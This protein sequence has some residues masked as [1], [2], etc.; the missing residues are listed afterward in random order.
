MALFT[1]TFH[2]II[3]FWVTNR[4]SK[5]H[6]IITIYDICGILSGVQ[7]I[8]LLLKCIHIWIIKLREE[9]TVGSVATIPSQFSCFRMLPNSF[10][11]N[12][13]ARDII[14]LHAVVDVRTYVVIGKLL[15]WGLFRWILAVIIIEHI[16]SKDR[17]IS[18]G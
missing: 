4:I 12:E 2:D 3:V 9:I 1:S 13:L 6:V 16:F 18:F 17:N 7:D 8:T 15:W 14:L 5:T 11:L 10:S